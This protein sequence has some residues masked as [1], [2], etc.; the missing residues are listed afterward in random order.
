MLE[1]DTPL[2]GG[3]PR[4]IWKTAHEDRREDP[5]VMCNINRKGNES[6]PSPHA[7]PCASLLDHPTASEGFQSPDASPRWPWLGPGVH[8]DVLRGGIPSQR[9]F[10]CRQG[11]SR[12]VNTS[13]ILRFT[14]PARAPNN[15]CAP[16]VVCLLLMPK[17]DLPC[18][19]GRWP[20]R[21]RSMASVGA[22]GSKRVSLTLTAHRAYSVI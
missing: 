12:T 19:D 9:P 20:N 5:A 7:L 21:R 6:E 18:Y 14:L 1:G 15:A 11:C 22:C 8:L 16:R 3:V 17:T 13:I 2:A 10:S 4:S